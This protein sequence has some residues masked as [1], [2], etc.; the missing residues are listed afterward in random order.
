[1]TG[2]PVAEQRA[3][4]GQARC[5]A[6]GLREQRAYAIVTIAQDAGDSCGDRGDGGR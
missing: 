4:D 3:Y 2:K 6:T 5:G 1:V